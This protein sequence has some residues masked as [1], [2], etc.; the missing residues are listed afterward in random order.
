MKSKR[1]DL[2]TVLLIVATI[3]WGASSAVLA[4][5][6]NAGGTGAPLLAAGGAATL[7]LMVLTGPGRQVIRLACSQVRARI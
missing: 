2:S 7:A 4:E 6:G 5:L 3:L 1:P